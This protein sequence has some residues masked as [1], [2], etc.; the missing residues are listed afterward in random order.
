MANLL[1]KERKNIILKHI[2][3]H[4]RVTFDELAQLLNV[5]EDTIRRDLNELSEKNLISKI[6]GG[7]MARANQYIPSSSKSSYAYEDKRI[8]AKKAISLLK[9]GMLVLVGG[10]TTVREFIK[11]IP[12]N[13]KATFVTVNPMTSIELLEKPNI[14]TIILGGR[15]SNY[16]QTV[17]GGDA[18]L[19]LAEIKA[20]LCVL[21]TNA[22]D[23]NE[24]ITDLEWETVEIKK[25]IFKASKKVVILAISEKLNTT[26]KL[27]VCP[28][29]EIDYLVTELS[30][31]HPLLK[32]YQNS[33]IKII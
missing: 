14:E 20:D 15:I 18:F 1:K 22:I 33:G 4:S 9:D 21:G 30:Q 6:R 8:I 16:S 13:L 27:R 32:A 19:K 7:A 17:I 26:M 23:F 31:E 2:N 11:M 25:A 12:E 29:N 3:I 28:I 24:G 5:S 10:G